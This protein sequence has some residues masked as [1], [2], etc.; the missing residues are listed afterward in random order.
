MHTLWSLGFG[1]VVGPLLFWIPLFFGASLGAGIF[2]VRW[3]RRRLRAGGHSTSGVT[4][5][6][7]VALCVLLP[8]FAGCLGGAPFS[9]Q[10]SAGALIERG[11]REVYGRAAA[12]GEPQ[13]R[14]LLGV[15]SDD[16]LVELEPARAKIKARLGVPFG[17]GGAWARLK[18]LPDLLARAYFA[19]LEGA[20]YTFP[21]DR[22][23]PFRALADRA[24]QPIEYS[25][26][27]IPGADLL[28]AF[29]DQC[30]AGARGTLYLWL[31]I[32]L[33]SDGAALGLVHLLARRK[34]AD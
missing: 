27:H 18:Q 29:A 2:A 8:P 10:R 25:G 26:A 1:E 5:A 33:V 21:L 20:A 6:M 30:Y 23:V 31:L 24:R 22:A 34:P 17:G 11:G 15:R 32:L 9:L 16:E 19:A 4:A 3:C 13:A 12:L 14:A 7:V 28:Q